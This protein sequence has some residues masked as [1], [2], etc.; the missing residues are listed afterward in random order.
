MAPAAPA[1]IV[2]AR[3]SVQGWAWMHIDLVEDRSGFQALREDWDRVYAADPDAQLFLSWSWMADWLELYRTTWF[4]LAAKR[5]EADSA[6]AAFLPLRLR[7][8]FDDDGFYNQLSFAGEQ[9]CDYCGMLAR[10]EVEAEAAPAFAEYIRRRLHW[11]RLQMDNLAISA[12]RQRLF[13]SPFAG[14]ALTITESR[15]FDEECGVDNDICPA[16]ALPDA[17]DAYLAGLSANNRQ[18][19]RRLLRRLEEASEARIAPAGPDEVDRCLQA[20]LDFWRLKWAWQKRERTE[21]IIATNYDML[22]RCAGR[23][24]LFLPVFWAQDR[25]VAALACVIDP[26]KGAMNFLITGRD[27]TYHD[28]PAGYLL[29]AYTIRHAIGLGLRSYDFLRGNEPYKYLLANQERRIGTV[30]VRTREPR[31]LSGR[32][33]PRSLDGMLDLAVELEGKE[34]RQAK[35]AYREIVEFAPAHGLALYRAARFLFGQG[36]YA[37]ACA[38]AARSVE[39]EPWGDN[40]WLLLARTRRF[41]G[42]ER[43]ALEAFREVLKLQPGNEEAQRGVVQFASMAKPGL[44]SQGPAARPARAPSPA[45][46]QDLLSIGGL[47]RPAAPSWP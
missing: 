30:T 42:D 40:A 28:M 18:K 14:R 43:G 7:T 5:D 27:E 10:P 31:N 33:D 11:A 26:A 37:E 38:L 46:T 8:F 32:L 21:R 22:S 1:P 15:S 2:H 44:A 9:F 25:V 3:A 47:A 29:H 23:G 13:L 45:L 20:L 34:P 17:W 36:A 35:K 12:R 39:A 24:S 16:A 19:I 41:L 4:V 6:Y